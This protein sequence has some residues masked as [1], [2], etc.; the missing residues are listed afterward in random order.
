VEANQ[1]LRQIQLTDPERWKK[2]S[3]RSQP[4]LEPDASKGNP[5]EAGDED[6]FEGDVN[7]D[8]DGA[9]AIDDLVEAIT[10]GADGVEPV[11]HLVVMPE[12]N[13]ALTDDAEDVEDDAEEGQ[14]L[15]VSELI[16]EI[17]EHGRCLGKRRCTKSRRYSEV[18]ESH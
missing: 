15:T 14:V 16:R 11:N 8:D 13:I 17:E 18:F 7:I 1:A 9:V 3:L 12:G 2:I 5:E 6:P 10:A 4:E